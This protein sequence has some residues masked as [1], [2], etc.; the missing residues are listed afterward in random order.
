MIWRPAL[1]YMQRHWS[2]RSGKNAVHDEGSREPATQEVT[3][4]VEGMS[5]VKLQFQNQGERLKAPGKPFMH[6]AASGQWEF[7]FSVF[8]AA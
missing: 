3:Q 7:S 1:G 8:S 5:H 2:E 4:R 6:G